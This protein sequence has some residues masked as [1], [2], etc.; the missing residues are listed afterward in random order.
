MN[1]KKVAKV[2]HFYKCNLCDYNTSKKANYEKHLST[3]KHKILTNTD[4]KVANFKDFVCNC[5]K[6]YK[7]RQSLFNHK[8]KCY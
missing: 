7:H 4:K 2:A 8:K 6:Q 3:Q 1:D 5:G